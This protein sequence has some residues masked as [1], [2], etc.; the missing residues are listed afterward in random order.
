MEGRVN[1]RVPKN[2]QD[3]IEKIAARE[4]TSVGAIVRD[5]LKDHL[6]YG[7]DPDGK[8]AR[9]MT[10]LEKEVDSALMSCA[11]MNQVI[12]LLADNSIPAVAETGKHE[13][14]V[15]LLT[16]MRDIAERWSFGH[17]NEDAE[18]LFAGYR[19]LAKREEVNIEE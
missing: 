11:I 18:K 6:R 1:V 13:D 2:V 5:I 17:K 19:E 15:K 12:I 9:E 10:R 4:K 14:I 16:E 3:R 8:Y 7:Y